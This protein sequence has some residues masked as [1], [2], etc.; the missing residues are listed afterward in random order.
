VLMPLDHRGWHACSSKQ[1]V[2]DGGAV[3]ASGSVDLLEA[4]AK[5]L[6]M[7]G[8]PAT[9]LRLQEERRAARMSA[10]KSWT[11]FIARGASGKG[12]VGTESTGERLIVG[13]AATHLPCGKPA[14][15][16]L[17]RFTDSEIDAIRDAMKIMGPDGWYWPLVA[18]QRHDDTSAS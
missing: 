10:A 15:V 12:A 17:D 3:V 4:A 1:E 7:A 2:F 13:L 18:G 16:L 11:W 5:A 6:A 9:L 8:V 14:L